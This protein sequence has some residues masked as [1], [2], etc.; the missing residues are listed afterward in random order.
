MIVP[1]LAALG[2]GDNDGTGVVVAVAVGTDEVVG[3]GEATVAG[4]PHAQSRTV[5]ISSRTGVVIGIMLPVLASK[6]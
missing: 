5:T 2:V 6:K 3:V 4:E 1:V